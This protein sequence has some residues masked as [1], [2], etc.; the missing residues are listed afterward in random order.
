MRLGPNLSIVRNTNITPH[1]FLS[2]ATGATPQAA[3]SMKKLIPT[4]AGAAVK[5]RRSSDN[6]T[7]DIGFTSTG[8]FDSSAF[9]SFIGAGSGYVHTWYDQADNYDLTQTTNADQPQLVL[10]NGHY[11]LKCTGGDFVQNTSFMGTKTNSTISF[12]WKCPV[13]RPSGYTTYQPGAMVDTALSKSVN[14]W[15]TTQ[16]GPAYWIYNSTFFYGD[17][18]PKLH[19]FTFE[20]GTQKTYEYGAQSRLVNSTPNPDWGQLVI[21]KNTVNSGDLYVAE[22][23]VWDS[24]VSAESLYDVYQVNYSSLLPGASD[25]VFVVVG[26]SNSTT[27]YTNLGLSWV[28]TAFSGFTNWYGQVQGGIKISQWNTD[29]SMISWYAQNLAYNKIVAVIF[30][31]TNDIYLDGI[32]GAQAFTRLE[33]FVQNLKSD[34]F[35]EVMVI[36]LLPRLDSASAP[37]IAFEANRQTFNSSVVTN[38]NAYFD[39]ILDVE[40]D[41]ANIGTNGDQ[42]STTRYINDYTHL[43]ATGSLELGNAAALELAAI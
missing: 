8:Q 13:T 14:P 36:T 35:D 3:Y 16:Q 41:C 22:C 30:L 1:L 26:D 23:A 37:G 2:V 19:T 24:A 25:T 34:G 12:V 15:W 42:D 43:N 4:Y 20:N 29:R 33:T 38:A 39:Y 17:G 32:T 5:I 31:G 7:Q 18:C 10:Q 27:T 28:N 9:T 40:N 21:G 6:T 11:M